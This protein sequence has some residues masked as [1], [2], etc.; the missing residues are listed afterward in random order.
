MDNDVLER[1][2][3]GWDWRTQG[4]PDY[5]FT[6][7]CFITFTGRAIAAIA[8]RKQR[9]DYLLC[10]YAAHAPIAFAY[11]D[12]TI[13][14]T[15]VGYYEGHF[16]PHQ[17]FESYACL[18]AYQGLKGIAHMDKEL[19]QH[20]VIPNAY[21]L[22]EFG[23]RDR[24]HD[25]LLFTR[26]ITRAKGIDLAVEVAERAHKRLVIAGPK[27]TPKRWGGGYRLRRRTE[28]VG[29]AGLDQRPELLAN[30]SAILCPSRYIELFCGVHV[31]AMLSG[32]PAVTSDWGAFAEYNIHGETGFRCRSVNQFVRA[33]E[34]LDQIDP[35][36]CWGWA[37]GK[38]AMGVVARQYERFL[39]GI[40]DGAH[41]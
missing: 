2:Y 13:V 9:G 22:G 34:H 17:A 37:E 31:E 33:V 29:V 11:P 18:H 15:G 23:F 38:F 4:V 16:A 21:D 1:A 6:D 25:Y 41:R 7:R 19:G 5:R 3:P 39:S 26:R 10:P 30:A 20:V 12:M 27:D 32:T 35:A 24:K 40:D 36:R 14:E 28:Y 8:A